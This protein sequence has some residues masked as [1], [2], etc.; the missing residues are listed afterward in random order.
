MGL[1]VRRV[2]G[3]VGLGLRREYV[4]LTTFKTVGLLKGGE[5]GKEDEG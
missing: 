5:E 1:R 4:F 2:F 3:G